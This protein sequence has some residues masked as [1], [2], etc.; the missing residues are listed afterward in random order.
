MRKVLVVD[1]EVGVT[2]VL[3]SILTDAGYR[4]ETATSGEEALQ[5]IAA[6]VPDIIVLDLRMPGLDGPSLLR[7]L[8]NEASWAAIPVI[9]MSSLPEEAVAAQD[10]GYAAFLRKP[11]R[12]SSV[13]AALQR[14]LRR[15]G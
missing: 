10:G 14:A 11:F 1:D 2:E 15:S 4:A 6:G 8:R 5:R 12:V 7:A 3:E 9:A 13:L